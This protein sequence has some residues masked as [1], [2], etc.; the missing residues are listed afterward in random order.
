MTFLCDELL[1]SA[2]VR[3]HIDQCTDTATKL[4]QDLRST[5]AELKTL[6]Y[7]EATLEAKI[8]ES[9]ISFRVIGSDMQQGCDNYVTRPYSLQ[10]KRDCFNNF[11]GDLF[12]YNRDQT[13]AA[14]Y[15]P[16]LASF[17]DLQG[18][19][20]SLATEGSNVSSSDPIMFLNNSQSDS[21]ELKS[22][23]TQ[24]IQ[25]N[26]SIAGLYSQFLKVSMRREFLGRD[27]SGRSYWVLADSGTLPSP[28]SCRNGE[29]QR[30]GQIISASFSEAVSPPLC[31]LGD[32]K[33][34]AKWTSYK[35]DEEIK[36]LLHHL[37]DNDPREKELKESILQWET[38]MTCGNQLSE[39]K[40]FKGPQ[41]RSSLGDFKSFI[42]SNSLCTMAT[43]LLEDKYG[44]CVPLESSELSNRLKKAK[45]II[46]HKIHRCDCLEPIW[47]S[48]LHCYSCHR[49]F[50]T[51]VEL[52]GHN[53]GNCSKSLQGSDKLECREISEG[54]SM[55][56]GLGQG[57]YRHDIHSLSASRSGLSQLSSSSIS[58][59]ND[60]SVC[61]FNYEDICSKFVTNESNKELVKDIGLIG[62]NGIPMFVPSISPHL[63]DSMAMLLPQEAVVVESD[64]LSYD[65]Q[66]TCL[67][68]KRP[69]NVINSS[70]S[71]PNSPMQCAVKHQ[72]R[73][74]ALHCCA[75]LCK[76]WNCCIVPEPSLRPLTGSAGSILRQLKI[77]LLDMDA[78]LPEEAIRP[79]KSKLE[80][81]WAWRSFVKSAER[82]YEVR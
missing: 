65:V 72:E 36:N 81:R 1:S 45:G 29:M 60:K 22:V 70:N 66:L 75:P 13:N 11:S 80:R 3:Q 9:D 71:F 34:C 62:S 47:P 10:S 63:S 39:S 82:I 74:I 76:V 59:Q 24:I 43:S 28:I 5:F 68:D 15:T 40:P 56:S 23:R 16:D 38:L 20:S 21:S 69:F 19:S 35:S 57:G 41:M 42:S 6:K 18:L 12:Q 33:G 77:N 50:L 67:Q 44:P 53:D 31:E 55:I 73:K 48:R 27:S 8:A 32:N 7:K 58:H 46:Q 17:E 30:S 49:T 54:K 78:A 14:C 37:Q 2:L 51:G 79:S 4:M 26:N 52:D 64:K 25:L 61:P